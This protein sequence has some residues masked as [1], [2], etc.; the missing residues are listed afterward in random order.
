MRVW[1]ISLAGLVLSALCGTLL[2]VGAYTF[3][4]AEGASYLSDDPRACIN[5]HVMRDQFD[6]WQKAAHH[7]NATCNDC[8]V[9]HDFVGKY[10]A[11]AE[12]GWRHS[13]AF[14][15]NNFHEP[16][17]ITPEDYRLVRDNCVRC[18]E[19][20][21]H[22]VAGSGIAGPGGAGSETLDCIRCPARVGHGPR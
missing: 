12:H 2:G 15:L 7:A 5:C 21:V 10:L 18:H 20:F 9:P 3:S 13:K 14:T 17:Q 16:I 22:D 1:G 11:K 8:H 19:A 4:Y 6:G